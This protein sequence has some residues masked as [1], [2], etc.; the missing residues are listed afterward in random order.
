MQGLP[1]PGRKEPTVAVRANGSGPLGSGRGL[2]RD[3]TP[4]DV[5]LDLGNT[6]P[7][8]LPVDAPTQ[9]PGEASR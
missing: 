9:L 2:E 6:P 1:Q 4:R 5:S 8:W 7:S 3:L